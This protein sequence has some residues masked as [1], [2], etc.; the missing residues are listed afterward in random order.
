[1]GFRAPAVDWVGK[2]AHANV[3]FT[4]ASVGYD[5]VQLMRLQVVEGRNFDRNV[6][7][8]STNFLI[9]EEAVRQ[10]NIKD[11]I[12]KQITVFGNKTGTIVGV[13][14][15][16]HTASL[17]ESID[18][19]ILD[20][21]EGLNFGTIIIRTEPGK[22]QQAL[23]S[24]EQVS[25]AVNPNFPFQYS[26]MD[27]QYAKLYKSEQVVGRLSNV[28][29]GLAIIISCMGLL[30]LAMFSAEQRRKELSIRKILGATVSGIVLG[31]SR[32][33]VKLVLVALVIA[34]PISWFMMNQW[35]QRFAYKIDL[36]W[37]IFAVA[38]LMAILVSLL[39]ISAQALKAAFESPVKNLRSE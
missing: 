30:G 33:F 19:L 39:T 18:P 25:K 24:L 4:M 13:L 9:N 31:F 29:A 1:M 5:F 35:L 34:I 7:A 2:D 12:G 17:H 23:Q 11:P 3:I 20:I 38:G 37:W 8:D 16:Y 6:K 36:A 26:F 32:D 28:F 22:T 14:K 21:K 27:Q 15:D 10:M